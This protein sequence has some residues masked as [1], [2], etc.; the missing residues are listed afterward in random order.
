M[1]KLAF[2][3]SLLGLSLISTIPATASSGPYPSLVLKNQFGETSINS[4]VGGSSVD[5]SFTVASADAGGTGVT[6]L[7]GAGVA[8]VFMHTSQT[9]ATGSPNPAAGLIIVNLSNDY[10]AFVSGTYNLA[11]EPIGTPTNVTSALTPFSPY[12]ISTVGTTTAAGFQTLGLTAGITPAVG[13][14]FIA[15]S[16]APSTTGTGAV[17]PPA[18]SAIS[19]VE[20]VGNPVASATGLAGAQVILRAL[21]ATNST[22]TTL[23]PTAP[24]NGTLMTLHL[25]FKALPSQLH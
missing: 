5:A 11:Q 16:P 17:A 14:P 22:T 12:I 23:I 3:V 8:S 20:V 21:A 13:V 1:K 10:T 2:L 9:P 15:P 7:S 6:G 19:S 25:V 24:T 4:V 18:L